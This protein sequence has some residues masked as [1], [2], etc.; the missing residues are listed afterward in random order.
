M[1]NLALTFVVCF[2]GWG[3]FAMPGGATTIKNVT[4]MGKGLQKITW[5]NTNGIIAE[6]GFYLNGKKHGTWTSYDEKG[7]KSVTA[8]WLLD[9]KEGD[10]Y[11][12]Y[13]NGKVKY[14][15]V[16][17][18]NKKVKANEWDETGTLIGGN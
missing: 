3:A 18:D 16:Y 1:K 14:H 2:L 6:E 8:T 13:E 11:V 17:S 4:D 5:Y 7:N 12:L 10:C 9:K 15:I